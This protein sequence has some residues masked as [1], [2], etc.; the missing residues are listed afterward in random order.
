MAETLT[1]PATPGTTAPDLSQ[2]STDDSRYE[3]AAETFDLDA[4][5]D[6]SLKGIRQDL[7]T[8]IEQVVGTDNAPAT[9]T[10]DSAGHWHRPDGSYASAEEV[11]QMQAGQSATP[12]T[13]DAAKAAEPA[14]PEAPKSDD[15]KQPEDALPFQFRFNGETRT[16][17]GATM[18]AEGNVR[19]PAAKLGELRQAYNALHGKALDRE[20]LDQIRGH[21]ASLE[22]QL[23]EQR[24]QRSAAETQ[25]QTLVDT[26]EQTLALKDDEQFFQSVLHLRQAWPMLKAQAEANHYKALATRAAAPALSATTQ[27][28][29][30]AAPAASALPS[31]ED[32]QS[33]TTE[34]IAQQWL[35]PQLRM[36][37]PQDRSAYESRVRAMPF[38][39]Y[40]P[41]TPQEAQ[42]YGVTPGEIVFDTD[43]AALD[44]TQFVQS[45]HQASQQVAQAATLAAQNARATQPTVQAPPTPGG[46]PAPAR[47]PNARPRTAEEWDAWMNDPTAL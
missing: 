28:P 39:F 38:A 40:R 22:Q 26:L 7:A 31:P 11:A 37:S 13:P 41:A 42:Q 36:L 24:Q 8:P 34:W 25:A 18:D 45:K 17:D 43:A 16:V 20:Y 2:P 9:L 10:Q 21:A 29:G 3:R 19:V 32:A 6:N 23:A 27:Q 4:L 14:K 33:Q 44:L 15:Q 1:A 35:S 5:V 46:S 30:P 12:T 47:S